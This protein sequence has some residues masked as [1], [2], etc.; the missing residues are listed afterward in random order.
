MVKGNCRDSREYL[1]ETYVS[2]D[3]QFMQWLYGLRH[4]NIRGNTMQKNL[5]NRWVKWLRSGRYFRTRNQL[6]NKKG[7][8]FCCLGVLADIQGAVWAQSFGDLKPE[9]E[10]ERICTS[11][12]G[13]SSGAYLQP[14]YAGGL[15]LKTQVELGKINDNGKSFK[16]IADWIMKNVPAE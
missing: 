8:T 4:Y 15:D 16:Y 9:I 6:T 12:D 3:A 10:N 1:V 11:A 5:R 2:I 13:T 14:R 7:N